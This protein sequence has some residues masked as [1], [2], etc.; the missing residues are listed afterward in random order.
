MMCFTSSYFYGLNRLNY[1][2]PS[3]DFKNNQLLVLQRVD[4]LSLTH[5]Y[6]I[7]PPG[8]VVWIYNTFDNNF[9]NVKDFTKYLKES[10]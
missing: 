7:V 2:L 5:K 4:S 1:V 3:L 10:W 8:I 6:L 9:G